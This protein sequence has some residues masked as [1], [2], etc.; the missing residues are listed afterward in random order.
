MKHILKILIIAAYIILAG[1]MVNAGTVS[2]NDDELR[3][4]VKQVIRENPQLIFETVNDYVK[5][6]QKQKRKEQAAHKKMSMEELMAKRVK[7]K[8]L[9]HSPVIGP[10]NAPV[11]IIEYSDFQCPGCARASELIGELMQEFPGK[12]KR[13]FKNNVLRNHVFALEAAKAAMAA[14]AQGKFWEFHDML[15]FTGPKL[16]EDSL[17]NS[18]KELNL[19]MEKFNRDRKSEETAK[20]IETDKADTRKLE[21]H[22]T[23]SFVIN[24]ILIKGS[25]PK[26]FFIPLIQRLL[27]ENQ[28]QKAPE[29]DE[30]EKKGGKNDK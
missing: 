3:E 15:F 8:I 22:S 2:I 30:P 28:A 10:E 21:L 16:N 20:A 17:V 26:S 27:Q 12:I 14:G 25:R 13:V 1:S 24:G 23:P 11:T 9:P 4:F 19:D 6:L 7:D 29:P 5:E 18:A